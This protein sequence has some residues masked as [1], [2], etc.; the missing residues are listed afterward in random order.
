MGSVSLLI[1]LDIVAA[2]STINHS[3]LEQLAKL[4]VKTGPQRATPSS[5]RLQG[6]EGQPPQGKGFP[7]L[8]SPG[9]PS[10]LGLAPPWGTPPPLGGL[11]PHRWAFLVSHGTAVLTSL[12]SSIPAE[13]GCRAQRLARS[14]ISL[15]VLGHL[16][17]VL[18][19]IVHSSLLHHV[20]QP[21]HTIPSEYA[22]ANVIAVASGVLSITAGVLAILVF[23]SFS[24]RYLPWILVFI[25]LANVLISG[26][27]CVGLALA[28]S[29]TVVN[30]GHHLFTG[31]NSSA[32]PADV[33]TVITNE[34]PFDTTCIYDTAL[35]LWLPSLLMAAVEA[36]LSAWSCTVSLS[37]CG[38]GPSSAAYKVAL[39]QQMSMAKKLQRVGCF[40]NLVAAG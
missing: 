31:C 6:E 14:G 33:H 35:V 7:S 34:C 27:C 32:L 21:A 39:L 2:F 38:T 37:L 11:V 18:G 29:L 5:E 3:I 13:V 19:A 26:A 4:G 20:A 24:H 16:A 22:V 12:P 30:G 8:F 10:H 23:R 17:L 36:G 28:I 15:V 40:Q 1:L 25:A 9:P